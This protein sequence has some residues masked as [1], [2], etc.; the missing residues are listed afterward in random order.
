MAPFVAHYYLL[1][2]TLIVVPSLLNVSG[3]TAFAAQQSH[4]FPK[5]SHTLRLA[6]KSRRMTDV[7]NAL[8]RLR[9][10]GG[11]APPSSSSSRMRLRVGASASASKSASDADPAAKFKKMRISAFDSMRFI[12][13]MAIV[14]G[15]F[16]QFANPSEFIRRLASN[17]NV[18]VG[19]FFALSGYVT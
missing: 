16:I 4:P 17:H 13:I 15:H 11:G 12:L 8:V 5:S 19:A 7:P 1:F 9:G 18:L 10:G 2:S 3:V 14:C 6:E